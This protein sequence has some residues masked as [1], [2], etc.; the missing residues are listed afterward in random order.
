MDGKS[1]SSGPDNSHVLLKTD[2]KVV[3]E[4][5]HTLC[6]VCGGCGTVPPDFYS[7]MGVGT[8]T[9]RVGCRRCDGLGTITG[10]RTVSE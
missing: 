1:A 2:R 9:A 8:S 5:I 10:T 7:R 6:P 3:V 4:T